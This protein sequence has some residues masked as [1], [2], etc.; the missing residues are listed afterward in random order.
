MDSINSNNNPEDTGKDKY[1]KLDEQLYKNDNSILQ[2]LKL[3]EQ[4]YKNDNS[5]LQN[6][7]L[8]REDILK[9][10]SSS[11]HNKNIKKTES[12]H[13]DSNKVEIG[14]CTYIFQKKQKYDMAE[15]QN[16]PTQNIVDMMDYEAQ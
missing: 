14:E 2:N 1:L 12:N 5:K 11:E 13:S 6:L 9:F 3:N 16:I 8:S 15:F 4:L 10:L 7:K